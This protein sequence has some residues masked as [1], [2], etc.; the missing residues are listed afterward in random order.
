M[1]LVGAGQFLV[2]HVDAGERAKH[3]LFPFKKILLY[4]NI[5]DAI[6]SMFRFLVDS[7]RAGAA[8]DQWRTGDPPEQAIAFLKDKG[9]ELFEGSYLPVAEWIGTSNVFAISFE[10]LCGD[11]GERHRRER[12]RQLAAFI[13]ADVDDPDAVFQD[14]VLGKP[15]V[16]FSG[17]RTQRET[18]WSEEFRALLLDLGANQLHA[19][20]GLPPL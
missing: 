11:F 14:S 13:E 19:R 9:A 20:L 17:S 5:G 2:G 1:P 12:L 16:T 4:R 10:E 6:L 15:T 8:A 7:G 18:Y 3:A